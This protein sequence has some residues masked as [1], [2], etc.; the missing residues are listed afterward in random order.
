LAVTSA[1]TLVVLAQLVCTVGF[2]LLQPF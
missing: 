1:R 2:G